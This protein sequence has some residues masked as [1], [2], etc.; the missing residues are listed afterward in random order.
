MAAKYFISPLPASLCTLQALKCAYAAPYY[1]GKYVFPG[2]KADMKQ[3]GIADVR[4][5]P[6]RLAK[7][8]LRRN[9]L[10]IRQPR[11]Y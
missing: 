10:R 2:R 5:R 9:M 7:S 8:P 11:L 1:I 3:T 6:I 4:R